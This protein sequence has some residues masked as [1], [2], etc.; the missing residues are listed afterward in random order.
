MGNGNGVNF[1]TELTQR[2]VPTSRQHLNVST[3]PSEMALSG[4][5]MGGGQTV[6]VLKA[7]PGMFGY[8]AAFAAGF[9][10]AVDAP[11]VRAIN[12]G[13]HLLRFYSGNI[14]DTT[15][16]SVRT[17][18]ATMDGIGVEYEFNGYTKHGHNWDAWQ[19]NLID[20]LPRLF[21]HVDSVAATPG[22]SSVN[23]GWTS[24]SPRRWPP[25]TAPARP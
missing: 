20:W 19:L 4:L 11:T 5:S 22:T 8:V 25:G 6:G 18:N 15:Y 13:T 17:G 3:A 23:V 16:N 2:I 1:T 10:G 14:T 9:G 24:S 12:D 7:H 21:Q